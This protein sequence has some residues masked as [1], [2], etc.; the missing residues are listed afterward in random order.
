M[1]F[2]KKVKRYVLG[3]DA[4]EQQPQQQAEASTSAPQ[5]DDA[6]LARARR[7]AEARR[8]ACAAAAPPPEPV[9]QSAGYGASGGVQGLNWYREQLREDRDGDIA[10]EF[11][12]EPS[13]APAPHRAA[14]AQPADPVGSQQAP[15]SAQP[16]TDPALKVQHRNL[17]AARR[18]TLLRGPR[19]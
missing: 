8:R 18:A 5:P 15:P 6:D 4:M 13:A 10:D 16:R 17:K 19:F 2:F 12:V 7:A 3:E 1:E 14:P 11:L 9:L